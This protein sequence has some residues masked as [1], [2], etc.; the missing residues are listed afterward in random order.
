MAIRMKSHVEMRMTG[1]AASHARTDI[2]VRDLTAVIDEPEARGG[3]NKGLT[4]TETLLSALIGCTNV[5]SSRLA[6]RDGLRLEGM[7]IAA[8]ASFDRRGAALEADVAVPFPAI[9][10][11]ITL[12]SDATPDQLDRLKRDLATHCPIARV[13]RAAGTEITETWTVTPL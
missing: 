11:D 12:R 6:E 13:L 10:L 1:T 2:A 3:T 5:I 4:P 9:A 8:R 7:E